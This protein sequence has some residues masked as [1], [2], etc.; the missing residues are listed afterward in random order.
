MIDTAIQLPDAPPIPGLRFRMFDP[1]RDYPAFVALIAAANLA[2]AVDYLPSIDGLRSEHEHAAE[3]DPRRDTILAEIEGELVAAGQTDVRTSEGLGSHWVD[4]WVLPAW[5]RR[6]LGR[7]LLHWTERRAADV[8]RVDGRRPE[9]TLDTWP[10]ESQVGATALYASE[11]YAIVRYGFQ[12]AR[13]L[14]DPIP[15]RSLPDGIEIRPVAEADHRAIWDADAEA[16]RDHW[17]PTD[18]TEADFR[19]WFADP[20]LDTGL[21]RVAWD[22]DEVAGS[23]MTIVWARE[24][25]LLGQRRGWLEHIATRRPWRRRGVAAALIVDALRGLRDAGMTEA[26]LGVDAEN[27]TGALRLYETLGFRRVR[28]GIAYRKEFRAE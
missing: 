14:A 8:A 28:T 6:G 20:D 1:S 12:M 3:F 5:R 26:V 23:V 13:G 21:W 24:N 18:R 10:D 7:A 17:S 4:G 27:P 19:A 2:D 16:F 9:R 15:D 25:E 22:G 11:G